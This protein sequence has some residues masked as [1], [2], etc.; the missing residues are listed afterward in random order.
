MNPQLQRALLFVPGLLVGLT[1]H[2]AAH[3]I[4]AKWLGDPTAEERGRVSLNPLRHLTLM[5]TAALLLIGIGWGKPVPVN[6]RN[7]EKPK[8]YYLLTSLA[9]PAMNV[10]ISAAALGVLYLRLPIILYRIFLSIFFVNALLAV[11]N[12]L[13]IPPLDGSKIW[14][15]I[16]PGFE[17][18]TTGQWSRIWLVV[19]LIGIFTGAISRVLEPVFEF[20]YSLVPG[21]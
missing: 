21:A 15:F 8:F 7:F 4:T 17:K 19:L 5:G 11:F 1:F 20:L 6:I 18:I 2:E 3:A 9:G 12:L 10:L 14:P 13:P 16:I